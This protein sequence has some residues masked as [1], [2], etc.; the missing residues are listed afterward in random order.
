MQIQ[1]NIPLTIYATFHIG[2]NADYFCEIFTK[3]D[4]K[5]A[6]SFAKEKKLKTFFLGG[7]SNILFSDK[8]FRG[9]VLKM[10]N[11]A[12][13]MRG[14]NILAEAGVLIS[15]MVRF[16]KKNGKDL[17]GFLALPGTWG[18]AVTGNAGIPSWEAK[19]TLI[20][21]EIFD[22]EKG[23]FFTVDKNWFEYEYRNS[24]LHK[25]KEKKYIVWSA[26]Q[27][28][29]DGDPDE[30]QK[31][32]NEILKMRKEKQPAGFSGGSFFKNLPESEK[33]PFPK[34]KAGW[35]LDQIGAKGEKIGDAL[36]PELHANFLQNSGKATQKDVLELA[37]KLAKKVEEKFGVRLEPEVKMY[38]EFGGKIELA[39]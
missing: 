12:M 24:K 3:E 36:V 13:E 11:K 25:M 38:D 10:K 33:F 7:G 23:D 35:M 22:I 5:E 29:P 1:K 16:A 19:D 34:N 15:E 20:S 6:I 32:C 37:R 31:K 18:G 21:A 17:S 26:E 28:A 8:G 14:E 27:S 30:I 9:I 4:L 39:S 2:G